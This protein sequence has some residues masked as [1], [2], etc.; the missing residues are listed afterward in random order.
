[1]FSTRFRLRIK[2]CGQIA[3]NIAL[4]DKTKHAEPCKKIVIA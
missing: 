3:V 4:F 1:M 2:Y